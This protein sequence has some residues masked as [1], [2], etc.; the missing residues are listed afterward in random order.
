M[1]EVKQRPRVR[2]D[3][4]N[5]EI[6]ASEGR[7]GGCSFNVNP[8]CE[9]AA[10]GEWAALRSSRKFTKYSSSLPDEQACS[11]VFHAGRGHGI[12]LAG[13]VKHPGV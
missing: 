9:E 7:L 12:V 13:R 5:G 2:L 6:L 4:M 3:S 8:E 10:V 11:R 1:L